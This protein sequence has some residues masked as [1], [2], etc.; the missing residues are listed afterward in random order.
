LHAVAH[1][2]LLQDTRDVR[3]GSRLADHELLAE[4]GV[5]EPAG[6]EI[7]HLAL[8]RSQL[9]ALSTETYA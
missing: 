1:A 5:R 4:L 9:A 6:E 2:K 8:A 7:E 3:L